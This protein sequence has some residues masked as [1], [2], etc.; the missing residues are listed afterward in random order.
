MSIFSK[1]FKKSSPQ[2]GIVLYYLIAIVVAF[3]LLNLP[4]VH[5]HGVDVSPIDT[6]IK[7]RQLWLSNNIKLSP[8]E[9]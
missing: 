5:K 4:F 1:L 6:I 8:V 9:G 7:K 3:L 2:Q